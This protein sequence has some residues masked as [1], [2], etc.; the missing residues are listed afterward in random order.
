MNEVTGVNFVKVPGT[1][2]LMLRLVSR[3]HLTSR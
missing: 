1:W 2:V 3:P